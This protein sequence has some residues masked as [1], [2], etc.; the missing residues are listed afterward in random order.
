M[1]LLWSNSK[2]LFAIKLLLLIYILL[3]SIVLF[4]DAFLISKMLVVVHS[5]LITSFNLDPNAVW[6]AVQMTK[7]NQLRLVKTMHLSGRRMFINKVNPLSMVT[8]VFSS[9]LVNVSL[10]KGLLVL[11]F[12]V[13]MMKMLLRVSNGNS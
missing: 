9:T 8:I 12:S 7:L 2:F 11:L 10:G 6:L 1:E 5:V 3:T 13:H 4:L